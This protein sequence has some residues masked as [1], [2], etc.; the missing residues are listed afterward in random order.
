MKYQT[1]LSDAMLCLLFG[2]CLLYFQ[3]SQGCYQ[4]ID[5][6]FRPD[7]F[8]TFIMTMLEAA[9]KNLN[10]PAYQVC[11]GRLA[12]RPPSITI[13]PS[14]KDAIKRLRRYKKIGIKK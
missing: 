7:G 5:P 4:C 10:I 14:Q 12:T 1:A 9:C 13:Y 6:T 2:E 3:E 8:D 11:R